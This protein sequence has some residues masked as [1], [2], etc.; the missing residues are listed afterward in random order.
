[1]RV[2]CVRF[3]RTCVIG[4]GPGHEQRVDTGLICMIVDVDG[5]GA[6]NRHDRSSHGSHRSTIVSLEHSNT[7]PNRTAD[8]S[9]SASMAIFH[10]D[11]PIISGKRPYQGAV[12]FMHVGRPLTGRAFCFGLT[13]QCAM[14]VYDLTFDTFVR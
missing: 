2:L 9:E 3:P 10:R 13:S 6:V 4:I 11:V 7:D 5:L 8:A 14:I 1:M 12:A